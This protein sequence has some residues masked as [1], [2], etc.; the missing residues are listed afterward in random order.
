MVFVQDL[1]FGYKGLEYNYDGQHDENTNELVFMIIWIRTYDTN[2]GK[3]FNM[4]IT[5]LSLYTSQQV[6]H[7][8]FFLFLCYSE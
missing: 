1:T 8:I 4:G 2:V 3:M 5:V 6:V 7:T